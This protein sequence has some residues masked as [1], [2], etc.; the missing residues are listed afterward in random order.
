MEKFL[1]HKSGKKIE[2]PNI[3]QWRRTVCG[4][5]SAAFRPWNGEAIKLPAFMKKEESI[6]S[7]H[8]AKFKQ[9]PSG[10][11]K[12][13]K[14]QIE[15]IHREAHH[16]ALLPKQEKG[17]R[18]ATAI[19]YELYVDGHLNED[20]S[21]FTMQ[22][23]AGNTVFGEKA[24]GSP[25]SVYAP[26]GYKNEPLENWAY[27]VAAGDALADHWSLGDFN[28]SSYHLRVYAPNGFYREFAGNAKDPPLK[29][30]VVTKAKYQ[31]MV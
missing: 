15:E 13:S 9:L 25:F 1:S 23:K 30:I 31:V 7:I 10:Y 29:C 20:K 27:T 18:S 19:P 4:D 17:I 8:K 12:L 21:A 28:N 26:R 14:A 6:E 16:S 3:T 24:A 11:T 5:L 2:E 22:L